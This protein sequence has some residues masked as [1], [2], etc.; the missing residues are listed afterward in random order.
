LITSILR[1]TQA[2]DSTS[3]RQQQQAAAGSSKSTRNRQQQAEVGDQAAEMP[4]AG[5]Q[6]AGS[7]NS[8]LDKH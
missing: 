2:A 5:E 7:R 1:C 3:S 4:A 6:A 8:G